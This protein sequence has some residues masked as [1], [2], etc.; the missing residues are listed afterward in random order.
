MTI[1]CPNLDSLMDC[2]AGLVKR[3]LTF[4]ADR[5]REP[6]SL[7]PEDLLAEIEQIA[8]DKMIERCKRNKDKRDPNGEL[9]IARRKANKERRARA[10]WA[11]R[12]RKER[13]QY[14]VNALKLDL[15]EVEK[16]VLAWCMGPGLAIQQGKPLPIDNYLQGRLMG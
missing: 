8:H 13:E 15:A 6:F 1:E 9:R 7:E 2:V 10:K 5:D 4:K 3:G 16:R 12:R 11:A 14:H